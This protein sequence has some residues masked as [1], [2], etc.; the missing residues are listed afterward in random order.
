MYNLHLFNGVYFSIFKCGH[1]SVSNNLRLASTASFRV[2]VKSVCLLL[3]QT[4]ERTS[5]QSNDSPL[6]G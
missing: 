1:I 4:N 5:H 3:L 6:I 2:R